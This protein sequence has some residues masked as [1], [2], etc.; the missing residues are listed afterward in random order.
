MN[1]DDFTYA[2]GYRSSDSEIEHID[3]PIEEIMNAVD[4]RHVVSHHG[5]CCRE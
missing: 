3:L 5:I 4:V 2:K 1:G